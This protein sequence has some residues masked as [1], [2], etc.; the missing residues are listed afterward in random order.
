MIIAALVSGEGWHV[1]DLR[2]AAGRLAIDFRTAPFPSIA[3]RLAQPNIDSP[4]RL[5]AGDLD[6]ARVGALHVRVMPPAGLERVVFRMDALH[7][8][9]ALGVP[10][11]NPPRAIETAVDKYLALARIH[12][13]G[14]PVPETWVGESA[15]D[16]LEAHRELGGDVVVKPLFG[17][18]GRG[19]IRVQHPEIARRVFFALER[20]GAVLYLQRFIPGP[21]PE[22]AS[23]VRVFI[24]AG[25]AI[26]AIRRAAAPGEW[27]ANVAAGATAQ[28]FALDREPEIRNL[29]ERAAAAVGAPLAGVD[30]LPARDGAPR[31]LE[32][33]AVPGWR[34]LAATLDRDVAAEILDELRRLAREI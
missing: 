12:A 11:L 8:L 24:L 2:R 18:E 31:V 14:I 9:E 4:P 21:D 23:D 3:A 33:N 5:V 13:A 1:R 29:A 7:R 25:R 20:V 15:R 27:R 10:V 32:I 28:P 30:I 6:L 19:L 22:L 16:A 17:A 34:A 26:G